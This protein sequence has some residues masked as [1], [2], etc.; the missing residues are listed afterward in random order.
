MIE[1]RRDRQGKVAGLRDFATPTLE[2][3]EQRRGQ[4]WFFAAFIFVALA[5]GMALLTVED[6]P[7][8]RVEFVPL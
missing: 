3:V 1:P 2:A 4:L 5:G 8:Q 6:S 7:I